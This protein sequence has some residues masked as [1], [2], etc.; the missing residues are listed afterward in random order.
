MA[1]DL[2]SA[3]QKGQ[4]GQIPFLSGAIPRDRTKGTKG[5]HPLRVSL[6]SRLSRW[7][8]DQ[9]SKQARGCPNKEGNP[10]AGPV[11]PGKEDRDG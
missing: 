10:P 11:L 3:G 7:L 1:G 5:T 6:L 2:M 8:T 9:G 4:T